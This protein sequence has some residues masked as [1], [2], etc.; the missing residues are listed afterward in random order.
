MRIQTGNTLNYL[1]TEVNKNIKNENLLDLFANENI[2]KDED[3]K[4]N[5]SKL[6]IRYENGYIRKYIVKPNG[7][8]ILIM[9]VKQTQENMKES[10]DLKDML[11]QQLE[12]L[13]NPKKYEQNTSILEKGKIFYKY[14]TGI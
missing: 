1:K 7:Q 4:N 6:E 2:H 10:G 5:K 9:E 8:R 3:E 13:T 11:I 14:K 12:K